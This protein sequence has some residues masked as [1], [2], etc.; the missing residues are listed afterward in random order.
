MRA[1]GFP[2]RFPRWFGGVAVALLAG[3]VWGLM[4]F[5]TPVM[6]DDFAF[7][8]Q[9]LACNDGDSGFSLRAL[10]DFALYNRDHDNFRIANMLAPFS[11]LFSPWKEL[12]PLFTG[13][14]GAAMI[15]LAGRFAGGCPPG[16]R[17][18][19]VV[20]LLIAVFLPMR[21]GMFIRDYSLNYIYSA[22]VS[23]ATFLFVWKAEAA[24]RWGWPR[25]L[26]AAALLCLSGG[27]H[28]SPVV[29]LVAGMSAYAL[30]G[31]CA[32][33]PVS[34]QWIALTTLYAAAGAAFLFCPGM[35]A[36]AGRDLGVGE[37]IP[38][39][40]Q[41]YNFSMVIVLAAI[42][43]VSPAVP[44]LRRTL[45]LSRG[46]GCFIVFAVSAF[47]G[48]AVSAI[49][50]PSQRAAF[51]PQL[52]AIIAI[53]LYVRPLVR[54]TG[55]PW[56]AWAGPVAL[57]LCLAQGIHAVA[58]QRHIWL[59]NREIMR[60][61]DETADGVVFADV[62]MPEG[63]PLTTL[64]Y[65]SKLLWVNSLHYHQFRFVRPDKP[66]AVVPAALRSATVDN[67]EVVSAD[68]LVFR[69]GGSYFAPF[70][71][72]SL[73]ALA[74]A[75]VELVTRDGRKVFSQCFVLKYANE[76]GDTMV[77]L[78]P[79]DIPSAVVDSVASLTLYPDEDPFRGDPRQFRARVAAGI[80]PH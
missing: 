22:A 54:M 43:L 14:A 73:Y 63:V 56:R 68:S 46:D 47:A 35:L 24:G 37:I 15:W 8:A 64:S 50:V 25:F 79:L 76:A 62:T 53:L 18:Q 4:Q 21:A 7:M 74:S 70:R 44:R 69:N 59:E 12:F 51:W 78:R 67:S 5:Y 19:A 55:K 38:L 61:Y 42:L 48:A 11:T 17:F 36:R 60:L 52:S 13:L 71:A 57:L 58:C 20:W 41:L 34:R 2:A 27:W 49:L 23:L 6:N 72:P 32:G 33:R 9:Y 80:K 3:A 28:E 29:A 77:Y 75:G 40:F 39:R 65:P 1:K 66:L 45:A 10:A 16:W 26:A 31:I 30:R